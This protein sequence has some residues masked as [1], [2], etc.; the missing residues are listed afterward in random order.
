M[1]SAGLRLHNRLNP[2]EIQVSL[3]GTGRR[4]PSRQACLVKQVMAGA[5]ECRPPPVPR[6]PQRCSALLAHH[7]KRGAN[8]PG[9]GA[10]SFT[11]D[12][13]I[14]RLK[15]PQESR[16]ICLEGEAVLQK[17]WNVS[18]QLTWRL[19]HSQGK[20]LGLLCSSDL[21]SVPRTGDTIQCPSGFQ[22]A[23]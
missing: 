8:C 10:P 12:T 18:A 16:K 17:S 1:E 9:A 15:R 22:M 11:R 14:G 3:K 7:G 6:A 13:D 4:H 19:R 5:A 23:P 21:G 20:P 2:A